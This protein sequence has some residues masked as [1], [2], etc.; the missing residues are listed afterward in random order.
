MN[1]KRAFSLSL[2]L[3][4]ACSLFGACSGSSSSPSSSSAPA[5]PDFPAQ[6]ASSA[7]PTADAFPTQPVK[8]I[9]QYAAGGGVDVTARLLAK[10]AEKHLGQNIVVENRTGGSGVLGLTALAGSDPDGYTLGL[11]FPNTA[12]EHMIMEGVSYTIDSFEPIVQVNFDPA[13]LVAKKGGPCDVPLADLL[14]TT[15][16][17]QL[18][19]GIGALW[20]GFDFVK[21]LLAQQEGAKFTRIA[22]DGGA[23]VTKALAAGDIDVGMQFPNEWVSYYNTNEMVGIA[24]ASEERLTAFPD[25]PTFKELGIDIGDMG[26]RR[27]LVAPKGIDPSRLHVLEEAFLKAMQDPDLIKEFNELGMSVIPENAQVANE[28]LH[29]DAD[30]LID[31]ITIADVKPGDPPN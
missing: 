14:A 8:I 22:F 25:V 19:M 16:Q 7:A 20:Q 6:S 2:V 4:L 21:L 15:K 26:V 24:V 18:N 12:V 13:F 10:Y 30:L 27:V 31:I 3:V 11:V 1:K 23:G 28:L 17:D 9:V 5:V 29:S